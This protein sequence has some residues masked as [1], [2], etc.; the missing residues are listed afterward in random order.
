M[1]KN[2][3]QPILVI[4]LGTVIFLL[5]YYEK[6]SPFANEIVLF[7]LSVGKSGYFI[8]VTFS[9]IKKTLETEFFYHEFLSFIIYNI[10]LIIFSYA[11]DYYCLFRID[12]TAFQGIMEHQSIL[13][14]FVTFVYFSIT[15]FT[16]VGLGD[17]FPHSSSARIF[18]SSEALLA[19]FFNI[20]IIANVM[21]LRESLGKKQEKKNESAG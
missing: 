14:E 21:H 20:L 8:F 15:T 9:R 3:I 5:D 12:A 16:S 2:T 1:L 4:A 17:I 13:K 6:I 18:V 10:L 11:V 7:L 19:F